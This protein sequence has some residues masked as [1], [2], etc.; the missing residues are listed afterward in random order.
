MIP[1]VIVT[2]SSIS[3]SSVAGTA[4]FQEASRVQEASGGSEGIDLP[5]KD[6][7]F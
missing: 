1:N 7:L 3:V 5:V 6:D 4:P 2:V